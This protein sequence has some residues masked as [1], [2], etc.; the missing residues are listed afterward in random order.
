M[1]ARDV[2][3]G[4]AAAA[5]ALLAMAGT[6]AAGLLLLNGGRGGGLDRLTAGVVAMAAGGPADIGAAPAGGLPIGVQGQIQ[7]MP[8]G[9]SLVGALVLGALLLRRGR[10]G[11]LVRGSSAAVAFTAG[12][13]AVAVAARGSVT[14]PSGSARAVVG[15]AGACSAGASTPLRAV[16]SVDTLQAGFSVA[17]GPATVGAAGWALAVVGL[18]WLA[19][20]FPAVADTLRAAR[21]P[22]CG[23]AAVCVLAAW[24]LGGPAAAGGALLALPLAA[25]GALLLGLGVPWAMHADGVLSCAL[26]GGWSPP[27]GVALTVLSGVAL[28]ACGVTVAA[29]TGRDRAGGPLRRAAGL[30]VRLAPMMAAVLALLTLLSRISVELGVRVVVIAV[31][32]LDV[33]LTAN[34]WEALVAG[35]GA[36]AAAGFAGSLLVDA[37]RRRTSVG[38]RP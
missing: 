28:L 13:C 9:V 25:G 16:G 3:E 35:L 11:L 19:A 29:H 17:V 21:W 38:R 18:C 31:P 2:Y 32:V 8:L 6:A 12:L 24:A 34:P 10:S 15:G 4:P 36:G 27:E 5:A 22:V 14:L 26:D 7:V 30:A 33:R 37:V 23:T 20:R 1:A